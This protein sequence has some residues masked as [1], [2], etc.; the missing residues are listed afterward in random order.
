MDMRARLEDANV[1][2]LAMALVQFTGD[3]TILDQIGPYVRGAW[4]HLESVPDELANSVRDRM[5]QAL[6]RYHAG[7]PPALAEPSAALVQRMMSTAVAEPVD[8]RYV[9]MLLEHMGLRL[10][11]AAPVTSTDVDSGNLKK[12]AWSALIVGAGASGLCAA[13][14]FGKAG[15]PYKII[16]KNDGIG[17]TWFENRYPGCAVDTPNHFYQ[18]SFEPNNA[19]PNYFSKRESIQ[20]YLNQCAQKYGVM[21]NIVFEQ[22]VA[23]ATFDETRA[24]WHV[25][26]VDKQGQSID[27]SANFLVCAVGQLSRPMIPDF[28]GK[29]TF[30]GDIIHTGTWPENYDVSDKRVALVGTGASAVQ[31]GPAIAP[32]VRELHVIQR[33]G[34]WISRRPNIDRS[35]TDN[36]KWVLENVPFYA[37]WYRFQLF[38]AFG[39]GLFEALKIDPQWPGGSESINRANAQLRE[40]MLAYMKRE[41]GEREDL[42]E[43]IVP[44]FPPFGKRVLGDPGW[45]KM[46][47]APNVA[48]HT[49]GIERLTPDGLV[50]TS[51]QAIQLDT[52]VCATGF[53]ATQML[54]PMKIQGRGGVL[55]EDRWG[56]HDARAYLGIT[57]PEFPNM[58]ILFG[59]NTNLGHGGSAIFLAE[60]QVRHMLRL[61][62]LLS[63]QGGQAIECREQAHD[64]YNELIDQ[65]LRELSWSH[66]SVSTW[67]KNDKG[68]IVTN[69]PW[70][71]V[72]YWELTARLNPQD[73]QVMGID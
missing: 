24:R 47:K 54:W 37:A 51:G 23:S 59:P 57:V 53:K 48:L 8:S 14:A 62:E 26:A 70:K 45:F 10:Q 38:W 17:G 43:K 50:L 39:D 30:Q 22:E 68:R 67:Y 18:Y 42:F 61:L 63:A 46:L 4:D 32:T 55:L 25:T 41:L 29:S 60:C 7:E 65:K 16:E 44:S 33:S 21:E 49:D 56:Q 72:E 28:L 27:Y 9:P 36:K 66:P 58:F 13:I 34:S 35:V 19:W 1:V 12:Q 40:K 5:V 69:Q 31:V 52:I 6:D 71:L 15:I 11:D 20:A 2:P 3:L 73:Y 64:A